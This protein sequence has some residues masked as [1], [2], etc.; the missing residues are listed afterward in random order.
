MFLTIS[1]TNLDCIWEN[2]FSDFVYL[3]QDRI[4]YMKYRISYI[5]EI[6][7]LYPVRVIAFIAHVWKEERSRNVIILIKSYTGSSLVIE[8]NRKFFVLGNFFLG[9][10]DFCPAV[11]LKCNFMLFNF[12][13]I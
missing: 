2:Q 8:R 3:L 10:K 11:Y 5:S 9:N 1:S 7:F 6:F 13:V 4:T 12:E